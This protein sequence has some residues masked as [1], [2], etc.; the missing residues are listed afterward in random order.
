MNLLPKDGRIDPDLVL[1]PISAMRTTIAN[2]REDDLPQP[3][4]R[5]LDFLSHCLD[6]VAAQILHFQMRDKF[7]IKEE[8]E[9]DGNW[10]DTF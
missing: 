9:E 4:V 10:K 3:L 5:Q 6:A 7:A 1:D 8:D 2:M